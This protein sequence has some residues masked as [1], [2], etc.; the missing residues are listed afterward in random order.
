MR[1]PEVSQFEMRPAGQ[2]YNHASG[3]KVGGIQTSML[4]R[5]PSLESSDPYGSGCNQRESPRKLLRSI[6]QTPEP[7]KL[8]V[9]PAAA[10]AGRQKNSLTNPLRW[11]IVSPCRHGSGT[12]SQAFEIPWRLSVSQPAPWPGR[13]Q[14]AARLSSGVQFEFRLC[15]TWPRDR[16]SALVNRCKRLSG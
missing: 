10:H 1:A 14:S 8:G 12:P 16:R 13:D 4:R 6:H 9:K 11:S 15:S 5:S 2:A 7:E 3:T